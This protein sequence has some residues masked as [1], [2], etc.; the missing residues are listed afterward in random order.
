MD[1]NKENNQHRLNIVQ[2]NGGRGKKIS[3]EIRGYVDKNHIDILLLQEPHSI[4]GKVSSFGQGSQILTGG[5]NG[6][7]WSAIVVFNNNL[8]IMRLDHLSCEHIVCAQVESGSLST[9]LVSAYFQFSHGIDPYI[10]RLRRVLTAL[11]GKRIILGIDANALSPL[12]YSKGTNERGGKMED[13]IIEMGLFVCNRQSALNT[14]SGVN[15]ESNI[16]V[17]LT[18]ESVINMIWSWEVKGGWTSSDHN[19]IVIEVRSSDDNTRNQREKTLVSRFMVDKADWER[20][21]NTLVGLLENLTLNECSNKEEVIE[22]ARNMREALTSASKAAIPCKGTRKIGTRWWKSEL[23]ELKRATYRARRK[24][25][26]A[27][28]LRSDRFPA[29]F[30]EYY[31]AKRSYDTQVEHTRNTSWRDYISN[32]SADPWGYAYKMACQRLRVHTVISSIQSE[33]GPTIDWRDTADILLDSFFP[34]D[35]EWDDDFEQETRRLEMYR[36]GTNEREEPPFT[37][38]EVEA[39]IRKMKGNKAPG[40]DSVEVSVVKRAYKQIK[41]SLLKLFNGCLRFGVIPNEWKR[42]CVVTLLKSPERVLTDPSSYRPICL[43]P[44]LGKVLE[45]LILKRLKPKIEASLSE[46]QYGF[47]SGRSTEDA[48]RKFLHD[49]KASKAKYVMGIFLDIKGAFNNLWWP[50]IIQELKNSGISNDMVGLIQDYLLGRSV[51]IRTTSGQVVREVNKGCPQGSLIGPLMW[52][53]VFDGLLRKL[54]EAGYKVT[55]YADDGA[56]LIEGNTKKDLQEAG[57][58]AINIIDD[59]CEAHKM[60][61]SKEKTVMMLL[62]GALNMARPPAIYLKG[63]SLKSVDEFQY[64][65]ITLS[66]GVMG[67]KIGKH[68]DK[69]AGK[70]RNLFNSLRRIAKRDWGLGYRSLKIIYGGLFLAIVTYGIAAWGHMP[71]KK[72]WRTLALAQRYALIGVTRAY[73]T[74]STEAVQVIAGV[75]PIQLEA[76]KRMKA[77]YIRKGITFEIEN[78][79]YRPIEDGG[80]PDGWNKGAQKE[81]KERVFNSLLN[82]WQTEWETS[83]KGRAT[84]AFFPDIRRRLQKTWII[85]NHYTSQ[86]LTGH[87][88]FRAKLASMKLVDSGRCT[89]GEL[90][91][92][93]HV[94][95]QCHRWDTERNVYAGF[96]E[97]KGLS[98]NA[99]NE[100]LIDEEVFEEFELFAIR[101]LKKK[102]EEDTEE[103][104]GH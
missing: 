61:L 56:I 51:M 8:T 76:E 92:Y 62:K 17:T 21:D 46:S 15:G 47:R 25:Q 44:V 57:Q 30:A 100:S 86:L 2:L 101:T 85:V 9:Y 12:W 14:F 33:I 89:C 66:S 35:I 83:I 63:E 39:V 58:V 103:I 42:S 3:S 28:R 68:I 24:S 43:L 98:L 99:I 87:G 95:L 96:L 80:S 97:S 78:W 77:Y 45:G 79:Y 18:T 74:V 27:R 7:P 49:Q 88:N 82:R 50:D 75:L 54:E 64:L 31:S 90:D 70:S 5:K 26:R 32:A 69:I 37:V 59:W 73:R 1:R 41:I 6:R 29:L 67:L 93:Q 23:T 22:M 36:P 72:H 102:Q 84:F 40:W 48:I 38:Q 81:A 13:F 20:F 52:N 16:D 94:I 19:A 71:N 65:G 53:L 60:K 4:A 34:D 10:E 55:A 11:K 104:D 91:T